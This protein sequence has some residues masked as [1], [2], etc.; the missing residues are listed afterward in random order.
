M[1]E[2]GAGATSNSPM[3]DLFF[4]YKLPDTSY[5]VSNQLD[6]SLGKKST[7]CIFKMAAILD[8]QLERY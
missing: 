6:F 7:K 4:I 3:F 8:F 1:G 5:Q 2:E